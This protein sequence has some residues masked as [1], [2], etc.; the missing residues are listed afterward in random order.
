[1]T[2]PILLVPG[3]HCTARAFEPQIVPLWR[4]G[5]VTIV[6]HT[7]G[8]TIDAIAADILAAAPPRFALAGISMGGYISLAIQRAAP[9]RVARLA[10]LNSQ[11][12]ADDEDTRAARRRSIEFERA[13]RG[14][15][16]VDEA[17][18][19][20]VHAD[21]VDNPGLRALMHEMHEQTGLEAAIRELTATMNR[22]DARPQLPD[23]AVPTLVLTGEGDRLLSPELSVEMAE[24][25]PRARLAIIPGAGH[26]STFEQ[27][28]AVTGELLA[29]LD[30]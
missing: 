11:A 21:N 12:R 25:I 5:S 1:M 22:P 30:D 19:A 26:M 15:E 17:M 10:L 24:A 9:E 3:L 16:I 20:L 18:P 23:I 2:L 13:G 8:D 28:D 14:E 27:P 4:R 29:W 7:R 6:D